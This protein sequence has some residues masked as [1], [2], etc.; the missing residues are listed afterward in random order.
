LISRSTW[1]VGV[2]IKFAI[3]N[4]STKYELSHCLFLLPTELKNQNGD[5]AYGSVYYAGAYCASDKKSIY[6]GVFTD[7][8]CTTRTDSSKYA[9]MNAYGYE[10]PYTSK[11]LVA[12]DCVSCLSTGDN[13]NN[14]N[15]GYGYAEPSEMCTKSY[16]SAAR[17]ESHMDAS[18]VPYPDTSGCKFINKI[19]PRLESASKSSGVYFGS[20][21]T[22]K[23]FAWIFGI[24]TV[25]FGAYSYF[26]Y[27]K[28][29]RG[30]VTGLAETDGVMA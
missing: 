6:M 2:S 28:I 4:P 29:K 13:N 17:C 12:S 26:L 15:N 23:A 10:L 30:G 11:S 16:Q 14:N 5:D 1:S 7:S 9:S 27:R 20:S 25:V 22:A 3:N 18:N 19:L 8:T 24:T 21:K